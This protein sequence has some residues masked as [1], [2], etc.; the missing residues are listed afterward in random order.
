MGLGTTG[1]PSPWS[2]SRN[3]T[4]SSCSFWPARR[5]FVPY[6]KTVTKSRQYITSTSLAKR[7]VCLL[8]KERHFIR[9]Y[10]GSRP[11]WR[12]PGATYPGA[13]PYSSHRDAVWR[14]RTLYLDRIAPVIAGRPYERAVR[15]SFSLRAAAGDP[16]PYFVGLVAT[17]FGTDPV[18]SATGVSS[19]KNL[20]AEVGAERV[21]FRAARVTSGPKRLRI[22]SRSVNR[23]TERFS[24]PA[25]PAVEC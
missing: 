22:H 3:G 13:L 7:W 25:A 17:V 20:R 4:C 12:P 23:R 9:S 15:R 5:M 14:W 6:A 21:V 11:P 1:Y 24:G 16:P 10:Q 18:L 2:A 19:L 8:K